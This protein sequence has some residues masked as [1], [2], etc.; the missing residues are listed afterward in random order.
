VIK[1]WGFERFLFKLS[2]ADE[3]LIDRD[4]ECSLTARANMFGTPT[5]LLA[6]YFGSTALK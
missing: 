3:L 2:R 6:R 4:S 1:R 5:Y